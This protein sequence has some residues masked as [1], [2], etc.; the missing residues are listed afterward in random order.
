MLFPPNATG[1]GWYQVVADKLDIGADGWSKNRLS[2]ITF[3]YDRSFECYF[4][5]RI[6]EEA[7][8]PLPEAFAMFRQ[9]PLVHVHGSLGPFGPNVPGAL[10]YGANLTAENVRT[11]ADAIQVVSDASDTLPSFAEAE[12]LLMNAE[13]IYFLGFGYAAD[14][15]RRLRIFERDWTASARRPYVSGTATNF[16]EQEWA[17]VEPRFHGLWNGGHST[18]P[19]D[20]FRNFAQ[21]D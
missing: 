17:L 4:T 16:S 12:E 18:G 2:V 5:A 7:H 21:L 9:I 15:L 6:G 20:F 3:N 10:A 11:A 13:R 8:L 19:K 14:N 1:E